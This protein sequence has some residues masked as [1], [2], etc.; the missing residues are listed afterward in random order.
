MAPFLVGVYRWGNW[1][2]S[3]MLLRTNATVIDVTQSTFIIHQKLKE[4]DGQKP[5]HHS[6]RIGAVY[7]DELTK[8]ISGADYKVGFINNAPQILSGDCQKNQCELKDNLLQ[9]EVILLKQRANAQKYIAVLAINRGHMPLVWNWVCWAKR[10]G[11]QN[12][13]LLAED[14][15]AYKILRAVNQPV[16]IS[17]KQSLNIPSKSEAKHGSYD[18]QIITMYRLEFLMRVLRAGYHFLNADIDTIWLSN[19]FDSISQNLSIT[20][21]RQM[22]KKMKMSRGLIIVHATPQGRHFWQNVIKCESQF[23]V[24]LQEQQFYKNKLS[25]SAFAKS[26]CMNDHLKFTTV[27]FLDPYLF[28]DKRSFFDQHLSQS[29]GLVPVVIHENWLASLES[30]IKRLRSWDLLASTDSSCDS[31]ENGIP[32]S[33]PDRTAPVR[34]RIRVLTYNRLK[35]LQRLLKSL[36]LANYSSDSVALDISIDRPSS[37]ADVDEKN[38]WKQVIEYM[39]DGAHHSSKFRWSHGPLS[40]TVHKKHVGLFGQWTLANNHQDVQLVLED[41]IEV[42]PHFYIFL[43]QA[44]NFYYMNQS[45]YDSRM[46]GL[47]LQHQHTVLGQRAGFPMRSIDKELNETGAPVFFKYQLLGTWGAV[48]FPE[49]W[50]AFLKWIATVKLDDMQAGCTPSGLVST[51]WWMER[52]RTGRIWETW[53]IRFSFERGWYSLYTNFPNRE[54]FAVSYRESGLNFNKTRGPMNPLVKYFQ[55]HIHL[56]FTKNP[57]IFDF[58]F[59]RI[60]PSTLLTIR[61]N[62]W[63]R[64]HFVNQCHIVDN[65]SHLENTTK[66]TTNLLSPNHKKISVTNPK[67]NES[68]TNASKHDQEHLAVDPIL[69]SSLKYFEQFLLLQA[70]FIF[71]IAVAVAWLCRMKHRKSSSRRKQ[72][73]KLR[74]IYT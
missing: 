24:K 56:N 46:F 61:S 25:A 22:H 60:N 2:L 5:L 51:Q 67:R 42:S 47:S 69:L 15:E 21:Q 32:Y 40:I 54:A 11:F 13:I 20:I 52:Y 73:R 30:K 71:I 29:R 70:I 43:K 38:R 12:Y 28:P 31:L 36:Q 10:I 16:F 9:S 65:N 55:P 27:K 19:P 35:S 23:L 8:N 53:F 68:N 57:P 64:H 59:T 39:G 6:S 7:N 72:F 17:L 18:F 14:F 41:D 48:F 26:E 4:L 1:L 49:H 62:L 58:H 74:V 44:I 3:E 34:I 33:L 63:H 50:H 66:T 37:K 45:N